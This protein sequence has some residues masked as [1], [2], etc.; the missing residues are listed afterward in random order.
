ML[1]KYLGHASFLLTAQNGQKIVTDPYHSAPDLRYAVINETADIVTSSHSHNDHNAVELVKG[2]PQV[3]NSQGQHNIKNIAIKGIAAFHDEEGGKKRGADIIFCFE[4]DGLHLC[5]MG[6]LGHKLDPSQIAAIKPVDILMIP[7]GGFF[8]MDTRT[9]AEV[10]ASTG[11]KIILPMHYKTTKSSLPIGTL[12][13]YLA[14]KKNVR[15]VA[16]SSFEI[17]KANLP[18]V[19]EIVVL[20]PAN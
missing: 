6:D 18:T 19:T 13:N 5:H 15:Q 20:T 12:D 1:I 8:T 10:A 3:I 11:T 2:N 17:T 16:S 7:V 14:D 9:A 4:I